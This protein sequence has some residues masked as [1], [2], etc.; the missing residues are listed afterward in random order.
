MGNPSFSKRFILRTLKRT[1]HHWARLPRQRRVPL[2]ADPQP[3]SIRKVIRRLTTAFNDPSVRVLYLDEVKF[4][5]FQTPDRVWL[6]R[7]DTEGTMIYNRRPT[8]YSLL[9][10]IALCDHQQ[11]LAIQIYANEITGVDFLFFLNSAIKTLDP[12]FKYLVLLDNASWHLA[13]VVKQSKVFDALFFNVPRQYM[14]N[15]I[16]N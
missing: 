16:G 6:K 2:Y 9:T 14:L 10:V 3:A 1:G 12:R 15:L 13:R 5:N 8:E 11:F 4:P 7:G